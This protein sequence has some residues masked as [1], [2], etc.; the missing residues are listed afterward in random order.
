[1]RNIRVRTSAQSVHGSAIALSIS[2][3]GM[4]RASAAAERLRGAAGRFP[5]GIRAAQA[6]GICQVTIPVES[7]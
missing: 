7:V 2:I 5:T 4:N 1:M 6:A 3:S